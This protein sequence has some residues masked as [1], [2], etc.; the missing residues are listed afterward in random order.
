MRDGN[1]YTRVKRIDDKRFC[2]CSC[3]HWHWR[4]SASEAVR[5]SETEADKKQLS[6]QGSENEAL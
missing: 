4:G 5:A 6:E 2:S 1:Y 3:F